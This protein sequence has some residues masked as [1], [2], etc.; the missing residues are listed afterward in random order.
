MPYID[1]KYSDQLMMHNG[2]A[3]AVKLYSV[4]YKY[5]RP[6]DLASACE[7]EIGD[8][9]ELAKPHGDLP[10]GQKFHFVGI[11]RGKMKFQLEDKNQPFFTSDRIYDHHERKSEDYDGREMGYTQYSFYGDLALAI[12]SKDR[13][14]HLFYHLKLRCAVVAE[15]GHV[16]GQKVNPDCVNYEQ[17]PKS[18][19]VFQLGY[20]FGDF[21]AGSQITYLGTDGQQL[22]LRGPDGVEFKHIYTHRRFTRITDIGFRVDAGGKFEGQ[23]I[24]LVDQEKPVEK[25]W[26]T[27]ISECAMC[28]IVA[29]QAGLTGWEHMVSSIYHYRLEKA[30][31]HFLQV[32]HAVGE[33]KGTVRTDEE[34]ARMLGM[35]IQELFAEERRLWDK[36]DKIVHSGGRR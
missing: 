36:I 18:G 29:G 35:T 7:I 25:G 31:K 14:W 21:P 23:Q 16:I 10:V 8:E 27:Q 4:Y 33:E 17:Y 5:D 9:F 13:W 34:A 2:K 22:I 3:M 15:V 20:R 12:E 24:V 28:D 26:W 32:R 6:T 1:D 19:D 11:E 30:E